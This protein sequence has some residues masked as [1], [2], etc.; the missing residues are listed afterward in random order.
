MK[1][2]GLLSIK[3]IQSDGR[4][5][6]RGLTVVGAGMK[7]LIKLRVILS[8]VDWCNSKKLES[9]LESRSGGNEENAVR[10]G[11]GGNASSLQLALCSRNC[12]GGERCSG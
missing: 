9:P 3:L 4:R 5:A 1:Q 8:E 12:L 6:V 7:M 2:T 10:R 11:I